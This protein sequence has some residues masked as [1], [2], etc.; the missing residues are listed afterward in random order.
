M[1]ISMPVT[2]SANHKVEKVAAAARG[3]IV[4]QLSHSPFLAQSADL[5]LTRWALMIKR[6]GPKMQKSRGS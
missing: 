1:I 5:V 3:R 2:T 4:W 6:S